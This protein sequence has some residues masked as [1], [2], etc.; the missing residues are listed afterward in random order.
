[1]L[2]NVKTLI[3]NEGQT[4][5]SQGFFEFLLS[6]EKEL[7]ISGPGG[8]GKTFTMGHMIDTILPQYFDTCK[9]MGVSPEYHS[10]HM[11]ATTNK[12]AEVLGQQ[13]GRPASTVHSFFGLKVFND[14]ATGEDKVTKSN[15]WTVHQG[16]IL[17]ID[18]A[19][20][21]DKT[22]YGFIQEGTLKCKIVYVGDKNQLAPVKETLSPVYRR[23]GIRMFELTEPMRTTIPEL[24]ALY[25]QCRAAVEELERQA[26]L[27]DLLTLELPS[28]FKPI[29]EVPGIIDFIDEDQ[30]LAEIDANFLDPEH[31]NVILAYTNKRV[32]EYN[33]YIRQLRG[34]PE[35][36]QVGD[37]L[38][39]NS[40]MRL[41]KFQI[42]VEDE[43]HV[44]W[45]QGETEMVNIGPGVQL[46]VRPATLI[47]NYGDSIRAKLPVDR[48]HFNELVKYYGKCKAWTTYYQ[49]KNNYPDLRERDAR[50]VYKIQG[51]SVDTVYI[52][53]TNL[54]TCHNPA[55]AA[56]LIYVAVSRARYRVV[57]YGQLADK[58]G[59]L[60][61]AS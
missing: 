20:M 10:V 58:Y 33:S 59:G 1:M 51:S 47:N 30:F 61:A 22:L 9:L 46:E 49:L 21:I 5:A 15:N 3:L 60:L 7:N 56:R 53:A 12:A 38:I 24:Q 31:K 36:F 44:D 13:T 27:K 6:D 14:Y 23:E 55:Q 26:G 40:A 2:E 18:E 35:E 19:S 16:I 39:S 50:T 54:S 37:V 8:V 29:K 48:N 32:V 4:L 34:L 42:S 28:A 57:I 17:F 41:G 43:L 52:D 11:T 45:V 25:S